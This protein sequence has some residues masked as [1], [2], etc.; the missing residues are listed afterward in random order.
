[1]PGRVSTVYAPSAADLAHATSP[2]PAV[3]AHACAPA[4]ALPNASRIVPEI[5]ARPWT[6]TT[7]L[8]DS[9]R[10]TMTTPSARRRPAGGVARTAYVPGTTSTTA[11]PSA[12]L[13]PQRSSPPT[14]AAHSLASAT[15]PVGPTTRRVTGRAARAGATQSGGGAGRG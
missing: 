6:V 14:R 15:G 4:T 5:V 10:S 11:R 7:A 13:V 12:P 8:V 3:C 1:M 9:L 2:E